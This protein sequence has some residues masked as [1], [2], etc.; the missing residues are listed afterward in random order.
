VPKRSEYPPEAGGLA[1]GLVAM[2]I[3]IQLS[4]WAYFLTQM[5]PAGH[6]DFRSNYIAGYLLRTG[7]PLYDY[8]AQF[9]A[10][11]RIVSNAEVVLPFI[12]PAYE[13][14]LYLPP[15]LFPYPQAFWL[16]FG[17]NITILALIYRLLR[18]DL[19]ALAPIFPALPAVAIAAFLPFGVALVQ[20]QDSLLL[21]MLMALAFARFRMRDDSLL[22][23]V[24]LGIGAFRFQIVLPLCVCFL[25][26]R[27]WKTT[28]GFVATILPAAALSIAISGLWPYIHTLQNVQDP[29]RIPIPTSYLPVE[30]MVSLRALIQVSGGGA[31]TVIVVSFLVLGV[32]ILCGR[33]STTQHQ[34]VLAIAAASLVSYHAFV[35]DLGILFIPCAY[36]FARK[37][38]T[39]QFI[40]AAVF[41]TPALMVFSQ[42]HSYLT[43]F[44]TL[45]LYVYLALLALLPEFHRD[46]S[47]EPSAAAVA[48]LSQ[49]Q[50]RS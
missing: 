41:V 50:S 3:G 4:N 45:A 7:K 24:C 12:H 43:V 49:A 42:D 2:L 8:A 44:G 18:T 20:G 25:L 22:A 47:A 27:R 19:G 39:A 16:W 1:L 17:V 31:W 28:A 32:T 37:T 36:L 21:T 35:H 23:G 13:A 11:N 15:S 29:S 38:I 10:Q 40:A 46:Q 6:A 5:V 30:R 34:F 48:N 26:W 9:E 14:V 33:R